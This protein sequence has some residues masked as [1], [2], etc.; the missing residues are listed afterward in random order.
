MVMMER[1]RRAGMLPFTVI[2]GGQLVSMLGTSMS[3]FAL[4]IWL[5]GQ[6]HEALS[7]TLVGVSAAVPALLIA[8]FAGALVDR[9]NRKRVMI[10]ADL[11]AGLSSLALLL[12]YTGGGLQ[13][14]HLYAASAIA[15]VAGQFQYLAYSAAT[16]HLVPKAQYA[17]ASGM[18]S[19][20]Q[21]ASQI[22]APLL[23][24]LLLGLI[25]LTGI[26]LI[27]LATFLAAVS[28]LAVVP[29]PE[30]G[31]SEQH[32]NILQDAFYGF[33]Y[34]F[35]RRAL[36][37]LLAVYFAFSAFES[38]GYPLIVPMI[39]ART[40]N[41]QVI[42]GSVQT[43]MALGGVLGG[44]LLTIWGGPKR[45]I[46]GILLSLALTGFLGDMV[47]GMGQIFPVWW[48]GGFFLEVFIPTMLG[49]DRAIWQSKVPPEAQGRVFAARGIIAT[50]AEPLAMALAGVL[51]DHV[52]EPALMPG[53]TLTGVLGGLVGVGPGAGMGLL[54]VICGLLCGLA[55][56]AGYAF[57]IIRQVEDILPD[58][59]SAA[60]AQP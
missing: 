12:L 27:D 51:A 21:Y 44:V 10:A 53:G 16:T 39:L 6:T 45:R 40:N 31:K 42:L 19:L 2:W 35:N 26:L 11:A 29:V 7:M 4:M 28:A 32:E 17:R 37:G 15:S 8:P 13:P 20:A 56:I 58:H 30:P 41:N 14:W 25:G 54:L 43:V 9:W 1:I 57:Q 18:M 3:R 22:G 23:A 49:S 60:P 59:V 24:G 52:F 34:I 33:R 36:M 46:H 48:L 55:S 38:L 50:I 47:M 5:W